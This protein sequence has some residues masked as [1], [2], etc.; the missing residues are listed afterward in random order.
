MIILVYN[1]LHITLDQSW[2]LKIDCTNLF[3][4]KGTFIMLICDIELVFHL[5][6][7]T[8]NY[9]RNHV[10]IGWATCYYN[11]LSDRSTGCIKSN[12]VIKGR[13][14]LLYKQRFLKKAITAKLFLT[15]KIYYY[16]QLCRNISFKS[17]MI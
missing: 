4:L 5:Y 14:K 16:E 6:N 15:V 7:C 12:T 2:S 10:K 1:D 8:F 11:L 9:T 17:P 13:F 3:C